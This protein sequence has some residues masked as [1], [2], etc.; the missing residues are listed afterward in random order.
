MDIDDV[1]EAI[2]AA[3]NT[4]ALDI[5][6]QR[7]TATAFA[8]DALTTPHFFPAEFVG[9]YEKSF[10]GLAEL[11][12]T[13]RLMLSRADDLS[14]QQMAQRLA[15]TGESTI[16]S[17]IRSARGAPGQE[18]LSGAADDIHLQRVQGPRLYE[19][20]QASFYGLEFTIFVMG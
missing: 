3:V 10:N 11:V 17:V 15:G 19:I 8:P 1:Y 14:G 9:S 7:L 13:G 4:A 6:G 12:I 2:A 20:G 16:R 5:N 18:A